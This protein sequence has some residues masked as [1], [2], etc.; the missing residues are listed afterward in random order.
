[1][2]VRFDRL[3]ILANSIEYY[4]FLRNVILTF[5]QVDITKTLRNRGP[6]GAQLWFGASALIAFGFYRVGQYN[7]QRAGEKLEE[8]TARY[9]LAPYLQAEEDRWYNEREKEI[10]SKEAA[11]MK[12]V[13]GWTVGESTYL[14]KRWV[15]RQ[16]APLDRNL[17]K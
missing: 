2:Y 13:P 1:M 4:Y 3:F 16:T 17:K 5:L 10:L 15:P 7:R 8:R 11:I 9:A 14:T 6:N 12:N